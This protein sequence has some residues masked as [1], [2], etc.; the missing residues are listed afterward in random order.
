MC[1]S[2]KTATAPSSK[3]TTVDFVSAATNPNRTPAAVPIR[4]ALSPGRRCRPTKVSA[5]AIPPTTAA[6]IA[7]SRPGASALTAARIRDHHEGGQP[8]DDGA[9]AG[10][11]PAADALVRQP[12]AEGE[13]EHDARDHERLHDHEAPDAQRGRLGHVA[14]RIGHEPRQPH[15]LPEQADQEPGPQRGLVGF[16]HRSPLLED[17]T[18]RGQKPREERE[19]DG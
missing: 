5:A 12:H 7:Q 10:D 15:R 11:L 13:R 18:E 9:G 1:Q 3:R 14:A 16:L 19:S 2:Q 8:D 6:V 4:A 17:G